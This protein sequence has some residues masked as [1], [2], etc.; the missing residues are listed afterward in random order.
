MIR[1]GTEERCPTGSRVRWDIPARE[2]MPPLKAYWYEGLN[3]TTTDRPVG[4]T[5]LLT[6]N[7]RNLPP[8]LAELQMQYP[9]E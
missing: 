8:L 5:R 2:K 6:G 3:A 9:D 1:G 4:V 7:A